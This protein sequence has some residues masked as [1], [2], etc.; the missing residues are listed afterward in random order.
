MASRKQ[1]VEFRLRY[2][3]RAEQNPNLENLSAN[4][5]LDI[6]KAQSALA[7]TIA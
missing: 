2:Y 5:A 4:S 1:N 7:S 3:C 6:A